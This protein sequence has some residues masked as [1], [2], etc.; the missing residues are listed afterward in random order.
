M[1]GNCLIVA[2]LRL[3]QYPGDIEKLVSRTSTTPRRLSLQP[4]Y[5]TYLALQLHWL[6]AVDHLSD[7]GGFEILEENKGSQ[8]MLVG[9]EDKLHPDCVWQVS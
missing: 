1:N 5:L 8:E 6:E 4:V 2:F 7:D 3:E 9:I